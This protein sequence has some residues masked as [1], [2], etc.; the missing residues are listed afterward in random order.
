[1]GYLVDENKEAEQADDGGKTNK[2]V[3]EPGQQN[4]NV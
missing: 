2:I 4:K 1:M 3:E